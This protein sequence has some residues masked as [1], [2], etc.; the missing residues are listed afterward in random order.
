VAEQQAD[1]TAELYLVAA[2]ELAQVSRRVAA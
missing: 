2:R 1:E